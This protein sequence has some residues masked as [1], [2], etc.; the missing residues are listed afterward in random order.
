MHMHH[1]PNKSCSIRSNTATC[2]DC[3]IT[4]PHT[5]CKTKMSGVSTLFKSYNSGYGPGSNSVF[6]VQPAIS[7]LMEFAPI[8]VIP[9]LEKLNLMKECTIKHVK[10]ECA[11]CKYS[12]F[13]NLS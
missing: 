12:Q 4:Y 9:G 1:H 8:Y 6:N 10:P 13:K 2:P 3:N 5:R 11:D 7:E